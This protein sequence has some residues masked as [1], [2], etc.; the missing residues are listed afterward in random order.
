M[1]T[2]FSS[3]IIEIAVNQTYFGRPCVNVWHM[4]FD[5]E[6]GSD[7]V[8]DVVGDFR[9]NWQDHVMDIQSTSVTLNDFAWRSLDPGSGALGVMEPDP[10]KSL[11]GVTTGAPAPPN[12]ALLVNK[13][14]IGRQRGQRDGRSFLVGVVE[15]YTNGDGTLTAPFVSN[16]QT[17]LAAFYNGISDTSGSA[18]GDRYPAVLNTT[19]A[20]RAPGSQSVVISSRRVDEI[21]LDTLLATQRDRLR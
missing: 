6:L 7:T 16:A 12:L 2:V 20:S 17:A 1:A 8:E 4:W 14:T 3:N 15:D 21:S 10:A 9:D 11:T 18:A 13:R 19:P 5:A